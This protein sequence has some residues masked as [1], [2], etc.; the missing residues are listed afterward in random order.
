MYFVGLY[1]QS[2]FGKY[3]PPLRDEALRNVSAQ[4]FL[5]ALGC[6]IAASTRE[7]GK[8]GAQ[9]TVSLQPVIEVSGTLLDLVD[10]VSALSGARII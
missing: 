6:E 7:I 10:F 8:H 2:P 4:A 9:R 1:L 3:F 5:V